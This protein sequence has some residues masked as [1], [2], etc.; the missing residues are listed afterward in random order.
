M[1]GKPRSSEL[2][3]GNR[4]GHALNGVMCDSFLVNHLQL[5]CE[6]PQVKFVAQ[7]FSSLYGSL[8]A[9]IETIADIKPHL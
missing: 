5:Q 1:V 3:L 4:L 9:G 2:H 6:S 8:D 7:I